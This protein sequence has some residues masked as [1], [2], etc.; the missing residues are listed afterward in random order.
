MDK[1]LIDMAQAAY[2]WVWDRFGIYKGQIMVGYSVVSLGY[3]L[4]HWHLTYAACMVPSLLVGY[5]MTRTQ[6]SSQAKSNIMADRLRDLP[7]YRF[8]RYTVYSLSLL[9]MALS[10][11]R[12]EPLEF[13]DYVAG[14]SVYLYMFLI[15]I[16]V[17]DRE[18]PENHSFAW[19]A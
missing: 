5:L 19:G 7:S 10:P 6:K 8:F 2:D 16:Y 11:W 14:I 4:S 3:L 12:R 15:V 17:R 13:A 9:F 18:P 1:F